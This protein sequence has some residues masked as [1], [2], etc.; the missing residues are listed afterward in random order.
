MGVALKIENW[1]MS[2][3]FPRSD[4][5]FD[6]TF[7]RLRLVDAGKLAKVGEN[8]RRAYIACYRWYETRPRGRRPCRARS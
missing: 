5:A 6:A 2:V 3:S 1:L 8:F 7:D 4:P